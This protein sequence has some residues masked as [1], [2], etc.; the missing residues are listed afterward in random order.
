VR[1]R[2]W[3]EAIREIELTQA[4]CKSGKADQTYHLVASFPP[5]EVPTRAQLEDIEDELVKAIGLEAHQRMSAIHT[6]KDHLHIH[7]AINKVDPESFR[8]VSPSSDKRQLMAGCERLKIKHGLTRTHGER[9]QASDGAELPG[10]AADMEAHS[11]QVSL[12]RWVR[13]NA[14]P[15]LLAASGQ[16][17]GWQ[18][19][20][21]AAAKHGLELRPYSRARKDRHRAKVSRRRRHDRR[22]PSEGRMQLRSRARRRGCRTG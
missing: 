19:L 12:L 8:N 10:A 1:R 18:D 20:H 7:V 13:E 4:Q 16:G 2:R 6:D 14:K 5:G 21:E 15:D 9:V 22:A 3:G 11:G 17:K